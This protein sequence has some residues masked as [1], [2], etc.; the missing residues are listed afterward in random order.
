[1]YTHYP[2]LDDHHILLFIPFYPSFVH[3]SYALDVINVINVTRYQCFHSVNLTLHMVT[4]IHNRQLKNNIQ[5]ETQKQDESCQNSKDPRERNQFGKEKS[6]RERNK[7][8]KGLRKKLLMHHLKVILM[9]LLK[10]ISSKI[11]HTDVVVN[12]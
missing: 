6:L 11:L 3:A 9:L 5:L 2:F 4:S 10:N 8:K 12:E 1:M 7:K